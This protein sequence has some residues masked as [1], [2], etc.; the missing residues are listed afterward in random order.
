MKQRVPTAPVIVSA[1][2]PPSSDLLAN[3]RRLAGQ[4]PQVIELGAPHIALALYLDG[5]DGGAVGLKGAFHAFAVGNLAHRDRGVQAAIALGDH[6]AL[7][8]LETLALAVLDLHLH[9]DGIARGKYRYFLELRFF[10]LFDDLVHGRLPLRESN[11]HCFSCVRMNSSNQ[12]RSSA[13]N[14]SFTSSSGR[15]SQVRP[16]A[17]CRRQR[18]MA[19]WSPLINT[20]GA[21]RPSTSSG[22]V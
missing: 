1:Q 14:S 15:R 12:P 21:C 9:H 4:I 7:E 16:K 13:L 17:C 10:N 22:R 8:S 2:I 5:S 18:R 3:A 20:G 19:A 11:D 6:H